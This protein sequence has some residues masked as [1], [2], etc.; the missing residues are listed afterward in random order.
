MLNLPSRSRLASGIYT[1]THNLCAGC[2]RRGTTVSIRGSRWHQRTPSSSL[3][4][5]KPTA[6]G[7]ATL[8]G[9]ARPKWYE[10]AT[11]PARHCFG[12]SYRQNVPVRFGRRPSFTVAWGNA[13]GMIIR[14]R[15]LAEG[16]IQCGSFEY[17]LRPKIA[18]RR[19]SSWGGAPGYDE[20]RP[21]AK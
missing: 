21:S 19:T 15:R 2:H 1:T 5:P 13:P 4:R 12:F 11:S 10:Y 20:N 14:I 16:H 8:K 18:T 17:G 9:S 7:R 3:V 6:F